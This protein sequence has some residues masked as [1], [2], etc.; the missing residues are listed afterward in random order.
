MRWLWVEPASNDWKK[1]HAMITTN[2]FRESSWIKILTKYEESYSSSFLNVYD[3]P[4]D[5]E[6]EVRKGPLA[7]TPF[8]P[9]SLNI[10]SKHHDYQKISSCM[11]LSWKSGNEKHW[12]QLFPYKYSTFNPIL[13]TSINNCSSSIPST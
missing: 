9:W 2:I 5:R 1:L 13:F 3:L 8:N 4:N 7:L 12:R 11:N 10:Y 6:G